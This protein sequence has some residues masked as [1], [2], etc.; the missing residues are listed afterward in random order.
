M[1]L[2]VIRIVVIQFP[3]LACISLQTLF[4]IKSDF[5]AVLVSVSTK[6]ATASQSLLKV[7][8]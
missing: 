7:I 1:I 2:T 5:I 3:V 8:K 4:E 6:V